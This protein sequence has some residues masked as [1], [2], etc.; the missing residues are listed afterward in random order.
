MPIARRGSRR[1]MPASSRFS[2][3]ARTLSWVAPALKQRYREVLA[4]DV[5]ITWVYLKGSPTLIRARLRQRSKH[6]MKADMLASQF[7]A[8]EEPHDALVVDVS[9][10][11]T[12]IV[13]HIRSLT[14]GRSSC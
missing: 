4:R 13:Q 10:P 2:N 9:T 11:P 14:L 6:F 12:E 5:P 3:A 1:F 8:L 7:D